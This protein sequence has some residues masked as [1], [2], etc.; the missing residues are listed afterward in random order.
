MKSQ[1]KRDLKEFIKSQKI[2]IL[3]LFIMIILISI[4]FKKIVL[5]DV[6]DIITTL[7]SISA[8]IFT[9]V[10]LWV[11]FLYPNAIA[12]VVNDNVDY[13]KNTK[14]APRIEKLIYVI[15]ISAIVMMSTLVF[16]VT[17]MLLINTHF[18]S[19]NKGAI[20]FIALTMILFMSWLQIKCILSIILSNINFAN[21]LHARINRAKIEHEDN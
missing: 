8:A 13:I 3:V 18:Y 14:D 12:G 21:N 2:N 1:T 7:Q 5:N 9:I 11:G 6:K 20:K 10:G 16:Y 19:I 4:T 17:K 15:I